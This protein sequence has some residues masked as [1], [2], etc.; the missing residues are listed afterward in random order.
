MRFPLKTVAPVP[1]HKGQPRKLTPDE[2]DR[3]WD[4]I[5]ARRATGLGWT[6][7]VKQESAEK[8]TVPC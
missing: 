4:E 3:M 8:S 2:L 5:Q 6:T 1:N 7:Q